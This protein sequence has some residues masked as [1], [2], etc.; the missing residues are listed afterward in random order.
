MTLHFLREMDRLN[1]HLIDIGNKIETQVSMAFNAV[2]QLDEAAARRVIKGDVEIDNVEIQMEEECLKLLALYQPVASDLRLIVSVLKINADLERIGDHAKN[3]AETAIKLSADPAMEIPE[4]MHIIYKKARLML[5]KT[6]LAFVETDYE[7][8]AMVL[9]MDDEVDK[10]CGAELPRQI[11]LIQKHP[12]D[13]GQRLMLL[14]VCRQ[15]E[16]IGDHA[17]NIAE[18]VVYLLSGDIIRHSENMAMKSRG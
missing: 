9:E 1:T 8:A 10:M 14:S 7:L 6:L 16:R 15:L 18:D 3:I 17:S 4:S 12:E 5:R 2:I 13:A 11:E